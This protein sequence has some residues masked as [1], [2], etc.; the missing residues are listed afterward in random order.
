M[1]DD[2]QTDS[3]QI[4][5]AVN[6]SKNQVEHSL[7]RIKKERLIYDLIHAGN[8]DDSCSDSEG[9]S[10]YFSSQEEGV[11]QL[12]SSSCGLKFSKESRF[13]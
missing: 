1:D 5:L 9:D 2:C 10:Y 3:E 12:S 8:K 4:K 11:S 13:L 6:K 7:R